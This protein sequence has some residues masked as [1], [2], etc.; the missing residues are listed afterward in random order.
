[1]GVKAA[2][3]P[4]REKVPPR[5]LFRAQV[6]SPVGPL[7]MV[8]RGKS[9]TGIYFGGHRPA[10]TPIRLGTESDEGFD[11]I[12]EQLAEYFDGRRRDFTFSVESSG[13][14]FQCEVWR[15]LRTIP[16]GETWTYSQVAAA[17]GR[18][19]A[20]RA[21]AAANA[22]NPVSI[23]VPCHRVIGM[24]GKLT[25]YAGG[26][27]VKRHLLDLERTPSPEGTAPPHKS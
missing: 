1:M 9:L 3:P 22:R 5:A 25:G 17:V 10:P 19:T 24:S 4:V 26:I 23:V 27:D 14:E 7:T 12:R 21:V 6:D 18:P 2:A 20:V 15:T 16:Y 8:R 11:E 13:T